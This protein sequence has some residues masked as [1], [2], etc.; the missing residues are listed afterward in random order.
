M[1]Q[2]KLSKVLKYLVHL[3]IFRAPQVSSILGVDFICCSSY[4]PCERRMSKTTLTQTTYCQLV[5]S[6]NCENL[7]ERK[8]LEIQLPIRKLNLCLFILFS[9]IFHYPP[10]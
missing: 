2:Q 10:K 3:K 7:V 4:F 8:E 1:L 6:I 9:R 5:S